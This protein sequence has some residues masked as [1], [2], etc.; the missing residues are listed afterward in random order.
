VDVTHSA[1]QALGMVGS[2]I[3]KVKLDVVE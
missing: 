3:A 2:G 1:A